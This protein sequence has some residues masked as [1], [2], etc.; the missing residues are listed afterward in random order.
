MNVAS[1]F[2]RFCG[3]YMVGALSFHRFLKSAPTPPP[4]PPGSTPGLEPGIAR[5]RLSAS[6]QHVPHVARIP[7]ATTCC[8]H[9]SV[10]ESVGDLLQRGRACLLHL[11]DDRQHRAC[12]AL[13][14]SLAGLATPAANGI[15]VGVASLS[16]PRLPSSHPP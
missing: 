3:R 6:R 13:G 9:A 12:E 1:G 10:I 5:P 2:D 4:V 11:L 15:E 8:R 14:L 16:T 7:A